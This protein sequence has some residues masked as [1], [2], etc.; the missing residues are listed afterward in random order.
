M[1]RKTRKLETFIRDHA[2]EFDVSE[3]ST[4]QWDNLLKRL[5]MQETG[6]G[7]PADAGAHTT[8]GGEIPPDLPSLHRSING[9]PRI[10]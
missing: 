4:N 8:E 10:Q 7:E 2:D 6:A 5:E 3:P 1:W 9:E